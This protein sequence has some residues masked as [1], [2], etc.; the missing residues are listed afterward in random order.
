MTA[1]GAG[2][3]RAS[4]CETRFNL[5][6]AVRGDNS[7]VEPV[8]LYKQAVQLITCALMQSLHCVLML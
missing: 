5:I 3:P 2:Q 8:V 4:E 1:D 6:R 7:G